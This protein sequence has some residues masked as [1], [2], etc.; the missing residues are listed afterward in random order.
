MIFVS[1]L[2]GQILKHCTKKLHIPYTPVLTIIGVFIGIYDKTYIFE[3][4]IDTPEEFAALEGEHAYKQISNNY[5][6]PTPEVVFLVFLPA[7]IFESAFNS[8]WYTFKR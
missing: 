2:L 1:L 8:D 5:H 6:N 7:L 3:E 4:E